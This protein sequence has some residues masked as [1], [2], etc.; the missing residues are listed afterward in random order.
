MFIAALLANGVVSAFDDDNKVLIDGPE[1]DLT[2]GELRK[3]LLTVPEDMRKMILVQPKKIR[4]IMDTT[5]MAKV[6]AQRARNKGLDKDPE[7]QARLWNFELNLLAAA[8]V[9]DVQKKLIGNDVD[10]EAAARELYLMEKDKYRTP[11][12]YEASHI[13]LTTENGEDEQALEDRLRRIR[14]EIV[15]G[16]LDF[17]EAARKYSMDEGTAEKG[18]SLG[19]FN[20]GR[21]V[22]PFDQALK[23]MKPGDISE[24]VKTRYGLHLIALYKKTPPSVKPFEEVKKELI[25][26]V[27]KKAENEIKT[28]YWL[29]VKTDPKARVDETLFESFVAKPAL[30]DNSR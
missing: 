1:V 18:G 7:L 10:Y 30:L 13:L 17:A 22:K 29:K 4:N 3:V 19:T 24:P 12:T 27:R 6:A 2:L 21:M 23:N 20:E 15:Q 5:Y 16:K 28:D 9:K 11:A 25:E 14:E 8:E 26:R